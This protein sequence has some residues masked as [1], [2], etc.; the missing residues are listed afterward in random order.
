M[1]SSVLLLGTHLLKLKKDLGKNFEV[2]IKD[3]PI[4]KI[5]RKID[6]ISVKK[7]Q[8]HVPT[9]SISDEILYDIKD[10]ANA[11]AKNISNISKGSSLPSFLNTKSRQEAELIN[12][13]TDPICTMS[14]SLLKNFNQP[15]QNA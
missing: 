8:N 11:M 2:V 7:V 3:T 6:K 1:K 12:F 5:H 15:C 4:S 14:P 9:L 10:V 13:K